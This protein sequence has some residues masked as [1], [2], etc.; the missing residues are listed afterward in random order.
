MLGGGKPARRQLVQWRA[1]WAGYYLVG[2]APGRNDLSC[3]PVCLQ[4]LQPRLPGPLPRLPRLPGLQRSWVNWA[5]WAA[6]AAASIA[7]P[8][9]GAAELG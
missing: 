2:A 5:E 9:W 6:W 3:W 4:L 8:A 7:S 1:G